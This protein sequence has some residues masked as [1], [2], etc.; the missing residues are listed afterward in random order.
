MIIYSFVDLFGDK[1]AS[2]KCQDM[3]Y[4]G[5]LE[6]QVPRRSQTVEVAACNARVLHEIMVQH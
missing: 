5:H 4:K 3:F 6:A 2:F 1:T